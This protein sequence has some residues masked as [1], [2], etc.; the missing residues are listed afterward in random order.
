MRCLR[1]DAS[2]VMF[3]GPISARRSKVKALRR[4]AW[5][6]PCSGTTIAL[7]NENNSGAP[8]A[9]QAGHPA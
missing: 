1:D 5:R 3:A 9:P 2:G 7:H 8:V 6:S 4:C